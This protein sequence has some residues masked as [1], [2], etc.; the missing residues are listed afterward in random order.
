M[1]VLEGGLLLWGWARFFYKGPESNYFRQ[2]LLYP[3]PL[4]LKQNNTELMGF[5]G[6]SVVKH[7]PANARALG[8]I[9]GSE[10]FPRGGNGHPLVLLPE[11]SHTEELAGCSPR[12]CRVGHGWARNGYGCVAI[13]FYSTKTG[14]KPWAPQASLLL[15]ARS[16][17]KARTVSQALVISHPATLTPIVHILSLQWVLT[18]SRFIHFKSPREKASE[19]NPDSSTWQAGVIMTALHLFLQQQLCGLSSHSTR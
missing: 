11:E 9:P 15:G 16:T 1:A 3:L 7:P 13:K 4:L 17:I 2:S 18:N 12:G 8:S 10:R 19:Q 14:S 6:G 5:P